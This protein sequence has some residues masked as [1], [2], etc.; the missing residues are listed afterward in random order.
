MI[1]F[2]IAAFIVGAISFLIDWS[3]Q[4]QI[5]TFALLSLAALFI[6]RRYF[7]TTRPPPFDHPHLNRRAKRLIGQTF[8][9]EDAIEHGQGRARIGDTLWR[10]TGPDLPTGTKI[11]VISSKGALL[12]VQAAPEEQN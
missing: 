6:G 9:L 4:P 1:W 8:F 7:K 2:G 3:W 11:V 10:V 12:K 5:L